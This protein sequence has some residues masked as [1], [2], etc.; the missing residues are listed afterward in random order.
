[1]KKILILAIMAFVAFGCATEPTK[2]QIDKERTEKAKSIIAQYLDAKMAEDGGCEHL[3]YGALDS[4][5]SAPDSA[6]IKF[7]KWRIERAEYMLPMYK[8]FND[9]KEI[10]EA[11][12]DIKVYGD[13]LKIEEEKVSAF[14]PELIALEM[15]H[16]YKGKEG[17]L[18]KIT[19]EGFFKID[20][21][22]MQ[23]L[24]VREGK[25]DFG[26]LTLADIINSVNV[27]DLMK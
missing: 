2:E 25:I 5:Y 18:A 27:E 8:R 17:A 21:A 6:R 3:E 24:D 4:V 20:T 15:S 19:A 7:C 14:V 9:K 13:S 10:A 11:E 1:M 22:L 26:D 16:K 23:V 12:N